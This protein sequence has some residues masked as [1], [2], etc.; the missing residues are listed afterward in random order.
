MRLDELIRP[1]C[2]G[3]L[4]LA[5][6]GC[7]PSLEEQ[8]KK[9][10]NSII[11]KTTQDIGKFDPNAGREVS[12]SKVNV[13]N[14]ITGP[15]E[16]YGPILEQNMKSQIDYALRLYE[17]ENGRYPKDYN[18][19]MEKIIKAN[20]IRLPVLPG[21]MQYQYDEVNHQLIVV[22]PEAPAEKKE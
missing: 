18:E 19:F 15:L 12:D 6:G 16:A 5:L 2:C 8:T 3:A 1:L 4:L 14:P 22:K 7:M 20:N 9:S 21:K 10:P 13:T 11:G 17:A